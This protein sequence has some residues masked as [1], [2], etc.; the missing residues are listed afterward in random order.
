MLQL[1]DAVLSSWPGPAPIPRSRDP[2][3]TLIEPIQDRVQAPTLKPTEVEE[4]LRRSAIEAL[5]L[6]DKLVFVLHNEVL[7][8]PDGVDVTQ[9]PDLEK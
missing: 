5:A 3:A 4:S 9:D 2:A 6:A 7:I 1:C 8:H